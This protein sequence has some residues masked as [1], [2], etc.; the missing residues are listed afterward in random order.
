MKRSIEGSIYKDKEK[1]VWFARLRYTDKDGNR[2]E[3]KRSCMTHALAKAE[4]PKLKLEIERENSDRKTFRELDQ[5][6]R[7]KY[8]HPAKFVGGKLVSGFRQDIDAVKH[9]LD[10]ALDFFGDRYIDEIT[11]ADLQNYKSEIASRPTMHD[12]ER[13]VSDTNH[14]L[15]RLRRLFN[16]AIEQGWLTTN[17][18][19]RGASLIIESFEVERTRVL[20][21][22]EEDS[23]LAQCTKWR[24]HLKPIVIFAIETACRRSEIQSLR[25]SSVNLEGRFI[26]IESRSTKTLRSRLVP[27]SARLA[28]LLNEL[29]QNSPKRSSAFVFGGSDFKKGF[30]AAASE[31]N[32][33]D[34][35]FHDLRHT[36]ITRML[37][38]GISPPLVMK[39]SGHTQQ[40]TFLRY[41]NQSES[42]VYE[43]ALKLDKAA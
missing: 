42:S 23:L 7:D 29:W 33:D 28:T 3:K 30:N 32:L 11:Y 4:V 18:F 20:S 31:A 2:R 6:F 14:F 8:V 21:P 22:A 1:K 16:V 13:S 10:K 12:R 43:I 39:I 38:K 27:I 9:Y 40:R 41:V 36:A 35:H 24:K 37:E 25:W 17:P 26:K 19:S 5:F 15:K 34:V